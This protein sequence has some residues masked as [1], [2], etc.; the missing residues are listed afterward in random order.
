MTFTANRELIFQGSD[1]LRPRM[2]VE[3]EKMRLH[4]PSFSFYATS[5]R[6]TSVQGVISTSYGYSYTVKISIGENYP[7][8]LPTVEL[9]FHTL[10]ASCPHKYSSDDICIM[11]KVQWSSSLSLALVV[12]KAAIWLNK[13]D[14]WKKNG[15]RS[16]PGKGQS[17]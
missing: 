1:L 12:A 14:S 11:R 3:Q 2:S 10:D 8:E 5:G 6:I 17:H 16:W 15:R 4:F 9:P 13:Y 7:Y